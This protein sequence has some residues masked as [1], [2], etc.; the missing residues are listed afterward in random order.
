MILKRPFMFPVY[1]DQTNAANAG[2]I[3]Q[4]GDVVT[5]LVKN[6]NGTETTR[7]LTLTGVEDSGKSILW[8]TKFDEATSQNL[9]VED[10]TRVHAKHEYN[11]PGAANYSIVLTSTAGTIFSTSAITING[12][13]RPLVVAEAV[14]NAGTLEAGFGQKVADGIN[15]LLAGNGYAYLISQTGEVATVR[16]AGSTLVPTAVTVANGTATVTKL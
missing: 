4:T 9:R 6:H 11:C 5:V 14:G 8:D 2:K 7:D 3:V 13:A 1:K 16:I 12:A 10:I 15:G